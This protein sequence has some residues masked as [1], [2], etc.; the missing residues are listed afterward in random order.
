M[1]CLNEG[2][3]NAQKRA[4]SPT[5]RGNP[6]KRFHLICKKENCSYMHIKNI[7]SSLRRSKQFHVA[8]L[9]PITPRHDN[10]RA[11][12]R[13]KSLL[14]RVMYI[15]AYCAY[16]Y[17]IPSSYTCNHL[18]RKTLGHKDYTIYFVLF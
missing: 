6:V 17:C 13:F 18:I 3:E 8:P 11:Q 5:C 1:E 2:Q 10:D 15:Q 4:K 7:I 16:I 9:E 12:K 14:E